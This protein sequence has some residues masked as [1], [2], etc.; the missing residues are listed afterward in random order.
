MSQEGF[1]LSET[2]NEGCERRA[3][4]FQ[5]LGSPHMSLNRI[6]ISGPMRTEAQV[7]DALAAAG[8]TVEPGNHSQLPDLKSGEPATEPVSF[9]SVINVEDED[10]SRPRDLGE[11]FG[12]DGRSSSHMES[13]CEGVEIKLPRKIGGQG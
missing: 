6:V 11:P 13:T 7:R 2:G 8:F 4:Y 5:R 10:V 9:L 3:I 1:A 12:W